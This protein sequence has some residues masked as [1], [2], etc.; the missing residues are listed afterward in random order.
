MDIHRVRYF[1]I[2]ANT[3]SL[4]KACEVLHIS[5]PALSKALRLLEAEVG[6]KLLEHEG[7][8]LKLTQ[9]GERFQQTTAP[10]LQQ[11][12]SVKDNLQMT[13]QEVKPT[14]IASFEV[15]TTHFLSHLTQFIDIESLELH[16]HRPGR[17][18]KSVADGQVDL[19]ITYAPIPYPGV[20]FIE[21]TKITMGIFGHK[22]LK[23]K[24][25]NEVPFAVPLLTTEGT[26]SKMQ[27]LDGWP[28]H[29][30]A[31]NIKYRVGMMSSALDL[32]RQ[33]LCVAYLPQFI[34]KLHNE[35]VL[36]DYRLHELPNP[37]AIKDRKQSV[38][39]VTKS[40]SQEGQLHRQVAKS[41]RALS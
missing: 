4:V 26:P 41:L 15:F 21:V 5:Q 29:T 36:P 24:N 17:I 14:R 13:E 19:G 1:Q 3:G 34:A 38:F 27:G 12:L 23:S 33:G 35:N 6:L 11:W 10:L 18:E 7:R 31:R 39:L 9:A 40:N 32:C 28:D 22:S 20:E 25:L 2:F 30:H 37:L 16:E 8:G